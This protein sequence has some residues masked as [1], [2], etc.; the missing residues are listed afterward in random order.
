MSE[1]WKIFMYQIFFLCPFFRYQ[2]KRQHY[3]DTD[4]NMTDEESFRDLSPELDDDEEEVSVPMWLCVALVV[5]YICGG[6]VLFTFWEK[7]D[8]LDSSY[9]CF[10][11]LTTI[12][13]GD[14]V[15]GSAVI[16]DDNQLTLGLCSLYL[17]FGMALLAMSFNLV[18]EEVTRSMRCIGKRIGIIS[19]DEDD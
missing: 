19:D 1:S 6:A 10:V 13:F 18:Q 15:P 17:L 16:S 8:F 5:S 3:Q 12:G 11:T 9:F 14:L 2:W 7:W 4:V